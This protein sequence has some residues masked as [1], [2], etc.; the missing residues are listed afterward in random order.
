VTERGLSRLVVPRG[1]RACACLI[2]VTLNLGVARADTEDLSPPVGKTVEFNPAFL[3]GGPAMKIDL[4]RYSRRNPVMPGIYDADIWLNG[5][6]Q[7]RRSVRF[8]A[9]VRESDAMPCFSRVDMA[10]LGV[11]LPEDPAAGDDPCHPLSDDV[12][13]ATTRFDVSEQ[14]LDIEVPQALLRRR[15]SVLVPPAQRDA[16][17]VSGQL[18]WRLNLHRSST[19]RSSRMAR[20]LAHEAGINAGDW[21]VRG[22][23][24][25]SASRYQRRHL[26]IERQIETWRS[27]WRAG[28]LLVADGSFASVRMR[29]MSVASDARMND[30]ISAGYKPTVRGLARTHALVRVTQGGV[31]L[32]ELSVPPGP[33]VID[34][35]EGLGQGGDLDVAI[36]EEDGGRTSFREPFFAMPELLGEGHSVMAT[37][38]GRTLR[39][40]GHGIEL[41]QVTWRRGFARDTTMYTGLRRWGGSDSV[42]VGAAI[43]T[44]AGAFAVDFMG[45]R[46]A[47]RSPFSR[48]GRARAWRV[49]H[50]RRWHDG[51][52]MWVSLVRERGRSLPELDQRRLPADGEDAGDERMDVVV[53]RELTADRGVLTASGSL[54]RSMRRTMRRIGS[55]SSGSARSYALAWTRGWGRA[56]LDVS[57]H[58][59]ADDVAARLGLS[60]PLGAASSAPALTVAAHGGG[61][62]AGRS[63]LGVAGSTGRE[64][65]VGYGAFLGQGPHGDRRLGVSASHL[66]STGESSLAIDRSGGTHAESF[67]S[68][69]ALVLH[70]HGITRAQRLGEAMALVHAPGA[71]GA[72]LPS[73]SGVRLDRRGYGVVPYLAPFRWNPVEIDPAGLSLDVSLASTRR[74]VAPTA[75]ALVLVPFDTE[76]GR[77]AL[78]VARLA[79]GS[80]PAFGA[81]VLDEQGRSVGVVGQAGNIFV[82]D[83]VP[84]A[85]LTIRW[86]QRVEDSCIVQVATDGEAAHGLAQ[87]RG[88]CK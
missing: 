10:S 60:M 25:W 84:G 65:A 2:A 83:V 53:Q 77:T 42:L 31:L 1:R 7:A 61:H 52:S 70:R 63:Q 72:R 23:A 27:Q 75:G 38:V 80:P 12:P 79:D 47:A 5:D 46:I 33:F 81:D 51:T 56:T 15:R 45:S 54:R 13:G 17:I 37:S 26:Y 82:R 88:I 49:R 71:A 18:G 4:S 85:W 39:T 20:F 28:D 32:R 6:W 35:L 41:I 43:D 86:G 57:F 24:S 73:T 14:R 8:A 19:G 68:S 69:G 44:L 58:H 78:L 3:P 62:G 59:A 34:D 30:D 9:E 36:E 76:V 50:G 55:H 21:R 40:H 87:W 29:G 67:A 11:T 16:G 22:A 48:A 64:G 74:S 66:S